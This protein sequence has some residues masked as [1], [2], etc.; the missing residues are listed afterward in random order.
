MTETT[1]V[2]G[3]FEKVPGSG[4]WWI[5]YF[6]AAGRRRREKV[7]KKPQAEKLVEKRR[8]SARAGVKMPENLRARP[9]TFRELA[10]DALDWS[11]A[12]KKSFY[13]DE[14][15]MKQLIAEFGNRAAEQITPGEIRRWL[16]SK[17][18][19][20]SLPTRNRYCA[21]LK[22]VYRVA[23]QHERIRAN[24]SRSVKQRKEN[25]ARIRYITDT[26]EMK[27]RAVIDNDHL[28]EFEI[29]LM[30]GMRL[31][32]Q[33]GLMWPQVD[34]DAGVIRLPQTKVGPGRFVR[35][36]DRAK[37]AMRML[38]D[39]SAGDERVFLLNKKP[40]WFTK[41]AVRDAQLEGI[42]WHTLRHTFVSRLVMA[43][44]DLRT[45]MELAGHKTIQMTMRYAH[46]APGHAEEAVQRL[47]SPSATSAAS[48]TRTATS[49]LEAPKSVAPTVN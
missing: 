34:L 16:D 13:H 31:S 6:D 35:L 17:A 20:W 10:K 48:A 26:E 8:V 38:H 36:N 19:E 47:C 42:T 30:T 18:A 37:A 21:L 7:G 5:Q 40:R 27:L 28:P 39:F 12:E 3:V 4:V 44:V 43:G 25:N 23:E 41:Q 49:P 11:R 2:R 46:L 22:M 9:V 14:L 45:V 24:P 29:G 1:K 32:E 15:R 33:F